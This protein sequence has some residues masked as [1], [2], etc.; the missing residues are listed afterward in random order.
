MA[1]ASLS[2]RIFISVGEDINFLIPFDGLLGA[3][4]TLS[5]LTALTTTPSGLTVVGGTTNSTIQEM[6]VNGATTVEAY[7]STV[8]CLTSLSN[9]VLGDVHFTVTDTPFA[10]QRFQQEDESILWSMDFSPIFD[11]G[12]TI[13]TISSVSFVDIAGDEPNIVSSNIVDTAIEYRVLTGTTGGGVLGEQYRLKVLITTSLS[14]VR[15]SDMLLT[16]I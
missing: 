2:E 6:R 14:N 11:T 10:S 3:S 16:I 12:E 4:E 1:H 13:S 9:T 7:K 15:R 5:S 8:K